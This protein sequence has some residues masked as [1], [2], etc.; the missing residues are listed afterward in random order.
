MNRG[1]LDPCGTNAEIELGG[2][3]SARMASQ[4]TPSQFN[5]ES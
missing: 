2:S 1:L 4:N 5:F 3:L